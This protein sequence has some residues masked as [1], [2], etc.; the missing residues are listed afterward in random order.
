MKIKQ[1][2]YSRCI[3]ESKLPCQ[4]IKWYQFQLYFCTFMLTVVV[5]VLEILECHLY[6]EFYPGGG[7][8]EDVSSWPP[9]RIPPM[10][11]MIG[12]GGGGVVVMPRMS[13]TV[14]LIMSLIKPRIKDSAMDVTSPPTLSSGSWPWGRVFLT[15]NWSP[16]RTSWRFFSAKLSVRLLAS[17]VPISKKP[18]FCW[19]LLKL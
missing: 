8:V 11:P 18:K 2:F 13:N 7:V 1:S 4:L 10:S 12:P 9:P 17:P 14:S 5:W 15:S 6:L 3:S 16:L 19:Y